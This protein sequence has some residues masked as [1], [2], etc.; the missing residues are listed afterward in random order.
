MTLTVS[1]LIQDAETLA[2]PHVGP[3]KPARGPLL[4]ALSALDASF[5]R[6][7]ANARPELLST[8]ASEITVGDNAANLAGY[9]LTSALSWTDFK[10]VDKDAAVYDLYIVPERFY[11]EPQQNP[12]CII[13]G[14]TLLP[15][16]PNEKRWDGTTQRIFFIGDGDKIMYN[17]IPFP[18]T[19]DGLTSTLVS[20]DFARDWFV[21]SLV[22]QI[23]LANGADE[24]SIGKIKEEAD[25]MGAKTQYQI[26]KQVPMNS[27]FGEK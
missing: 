14:T 21:W 4:R 3:Q 19:L 8:Q 16:D 24:M 5:A 18:A 23:A 12:S 17:Y 9:A 15:C 27:R 6:E 20:P 7:I 13:Q 22:L 2:Y 26:Y 10:Y 11:D 1:D 25:L